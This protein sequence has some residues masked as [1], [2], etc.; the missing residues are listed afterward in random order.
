[1]NLNCMPRNQAARRYNRHFFLAMG[2]YVVFILLSVFLLKH[3]HPAAP[4]ACLLAVLPALPLIASLGFVAQYV[5]E[6][7][8]E[9]ERTLL[10][11]SM[12]WALGGV[13]AVSTVWG[14]LE[15]LD[16]FPR[17]PIFFIYPGFWMLVGLANPFI[18]LKYRGTPDE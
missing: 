15:M 3:R 8:D 5:A 4:L 9:F 7:K 16:S 18:R 12:L 6:E 11:E 2:L 1:M 17:L 13:L 14:L 10:L